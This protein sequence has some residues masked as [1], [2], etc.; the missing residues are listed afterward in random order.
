MPS[1]DAVGSHTA[2]RRPTVTVVGPK[3][4][5]FRVQGRFF[6]G[7]YVSVY[8]RPTLS[9]FGIHVPRPVGMLNAYT[10]IVHMV[11]EHYTFVPRCIMYTNQM[12]AG[13]NVH[14]NTILQ[15]SSCD[16]GCRISLILN[17]TIAICDNFKM[18]TFLGNH[19]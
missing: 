3:T 13:R 12:G 9:D 18:L 6:A 19:V 16:F 14:K 8:C 11:F 7:A 4:F 2:V 5:C 10:R 15:K 17:T 1:T